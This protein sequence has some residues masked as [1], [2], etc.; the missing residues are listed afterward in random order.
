MGSKKL[1]PVTVGE[2]YGRPPQTL[3]EKV[4]VLRLKINEIIEVMNNDA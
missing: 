2:I 4:E 1:K 3:E